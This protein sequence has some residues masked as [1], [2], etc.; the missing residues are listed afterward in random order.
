MIM[1]DAGMRTSSKRISPWLRARCP[2]LSS[3]LPRE[4]PG[5]SSGTT[6]TPPCW[7]PLSPSMVQNSAATVA[8]VPFDTH[9]DFW[10]FNT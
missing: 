8:I 6:A 2:I 9:A 7:K 4:T 1:Y 10:P 3:G 5:R